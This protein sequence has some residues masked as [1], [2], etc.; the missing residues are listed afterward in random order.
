MGPPSGFEPETY[1]LRVR[2]YVAV[3]RQPASGSIPEGRRAPRRQGL[4]TTSNK[5]NLQ[6]AHKGAKLI[7]ASAGDIRLNGANVIMN[8]CPICPRNMS[9]ERGLPDS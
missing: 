8:D 2:R 1:A 7:R 4:P 3:D 9:V 5:I 6:L